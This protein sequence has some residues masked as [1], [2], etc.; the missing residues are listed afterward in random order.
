MPYVDKKIFCDCRIC[1]VIDDKEVL[2]ALSWAHQY[3]N[4]WTRFLVYSNCCSVF[5]DAEAVLN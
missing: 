5:G 1:C 3:L 2:V 4:C